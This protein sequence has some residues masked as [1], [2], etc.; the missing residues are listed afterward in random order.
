MTSLPLPPNTTSSPL[1]P[2]RWS[3]PPLPSR[4]SLPSPPR[5]ESGALL[6]VSRSLRK[7]PNMIAMGNLETG[8]SD[9][10]AVARP[11]MFRAV[12][13]LAYG[14]LF[15]AATAVAPVAAGAQNEAIGIVVMH[16]KGGRPHA[17]HMTDFVERLERQGFM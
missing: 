16:G 17:P 11:G 6:P 12:V 3:R 2:K 8:K 13:R 10:W 5:I 1:P 15:A 9:H 14:L 7:D 4:T